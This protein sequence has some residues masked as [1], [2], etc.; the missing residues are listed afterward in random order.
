MYITNATVEADKSSIEPKL[1]FTIEFNYSKNAESFISFQGILKSRSGR[2]LAVIESGIDSIRNTTHSSILI[3]IPAMGRIEEK[4]P[5]ETKYT[6][7]F[8]CYLSP[9]ALDF[10]ENERLSWEPHDVLLKIELECV[11]LKRGQVRH[12][13]E[14]EIVNSHVAYEV[15]I[16]QSDWLSK[17]SPH[18]GIG[19]FLIVEIPK[20]TDEIDIHS[21]HPWAEKVARAKIRLDKMHKELTQGDWQEVMR[22]S[23]DFWDNFKIK[24]DDTESLENIKSLFRLENHSDEG[25]EDLRNSIWYVHEFSS[26]YIHDM[27]KKRKNLNPI[28]EAR[29]EDAY[30]MYMWTMGFINLISEKIGRIEREPLK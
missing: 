30:F 3:P 16:P 24:K 11:L 2:V 27:D 25:L 8:Y 4:P 20:F 10:L 13:I 17:F 22:V 26:K 15:K 19:N 9:K 29:K 5:I 6:R 12:D 18:L 14:L 21:S 1:N 7:S 23:R 28:P